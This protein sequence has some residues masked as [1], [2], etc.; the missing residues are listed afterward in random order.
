MRSLC[1]KMICI[2]NEKS[3]ANQ[4][5]SILLGFI[6]FLTIVA[7]FLLANQ[8]AFVNDEETYLLMARNFAESGGLAIWSGYQE[9]P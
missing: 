6:C 3:N 1:E 5:K 4:K 2:V 9:Y 8:G 7:S